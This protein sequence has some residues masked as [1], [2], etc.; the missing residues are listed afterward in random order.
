MYSNNLA[1][2][3][4][5][6]ELNKIIEKINKKRYSN[7]IFVCIGSNKMVGDSLGPL[8]G[9]TLYKN[10]KDKKIKILGNLKNNVNSKNINQTLKNIEKEYTKP[11][12]ISIDSALSNSIEP[13]NVFILKKGLVPGSALK[14]KSIVIGNISIKAIVGKD[15]KN[16]VK[17]YYNLKNAD[18]KM[19]LK[20][21][22]NISNI[23]LESIKSLNL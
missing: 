5:N 16:L 4:F 18:Y 20:F 14:K 22:K 12:V 10:L 21:S 15:E 8:I 13:G 2:A 17:N 19:I 9:E 7:L 6:L 3:N 23:I 11:Y 1:Y